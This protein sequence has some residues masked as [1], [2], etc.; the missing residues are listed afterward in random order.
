MATMTDPKQYASPE[1]VM[2]DP[3][4]TDAA[5]AEVLR[6]W[7]LDLE[8]KLNASDEN[9]PVLKADGT[10]KPGAD[11]NESEMLR[12]VTDCLRKAEPAPTSQEAVT[13]RST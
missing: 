13:Q 7:K 11:A 8:L 6:Q 2:T 4:L 5:R 10:A 9:M 12:R 1:M 3:K